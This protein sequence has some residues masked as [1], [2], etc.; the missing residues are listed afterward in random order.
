MGDQAEVLV[1]VS[2]ISEVGLA[3]SCGNGDTELWGEKLS[4]DSKSGSGSSILCDG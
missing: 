1:D 4:I 2:S 3:K